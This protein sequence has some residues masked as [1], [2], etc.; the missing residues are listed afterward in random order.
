VSTDP[1]RARLR[2]IRGA[3]VALAAVAVMA[4]MAAMAPPGSAATWTTQIT[5]GPSGPPEA[6]LTAVSCASATFC[7]AVGGSDYGLDSAQT[8]LLGPIETSAERWG[9]S[10]WTVVP[11]PVAGTD[12]D[13]LAV[14]CPSTTFCVAVGQTGRTLVGDGFGDRHAHALLEAWNGAGW[15]VQTTPAGSVPESGLT[16]VSCVSRSFCIAVG[17]PVSIVWDGTGWKQIRIPT[18]RYDTELL[19]ISCVA[20]TACTAVGQYSVNKIGVEELQP[21]AERWDGRI[22]TIDR[23]PG[24]VDRYR[25]K[26]Y[27]NDT[28]LTAVSCLSRSF[29]LASGDA[30]R[31]QNGIYEGAYANRW[32]GRRWT[33]A[34]AGLPKHSPLDGIACLSRTNC[35][36]A[37]QFDT[38]IFPA[39]STQQ[40]LVENWNGANWTRI[41]LPHVP[42]IPGATFN[43]TSP[44]GPNLSS[45]SCVPRAGCTAVGEQAQGSD[46]A[47]LAQSDMGAPGAASARQGRGSTRD[48]RSSR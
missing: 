9:G 27:P 22:W 7:M 42:T 33:R 21:L 6:A 25:G 10:S 30:Q 39:A 24:E 19:G 18:A 8:T 5:P 48:Q 37:G 35:F 23:P 17:S 1:G 31:A 34:T 14:S 45:V 43:S 32:D 4:A 26:P 16:G 47:N 2:A 12:P 13:L 11:T 46:S 44:G 38:G 40:P 41:T 28:W 36:A 20:T 3:I 29:C 15:S